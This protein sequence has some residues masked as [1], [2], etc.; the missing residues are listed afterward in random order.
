VEGICE[1]RSRVSYAKAVRD[2]AGRHEFERG[3]NASRS[4]GKVLM[5]E[6]HEYRWTCPWCG[7]EFDNFED[8]DAHT[9]PRN[10]PVMGVPVC[11]LPEPDALQT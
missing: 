6:D 7:K 11:R 3:C 5:S 1:S 8:F 4:M 10:Q 2:A 9:M